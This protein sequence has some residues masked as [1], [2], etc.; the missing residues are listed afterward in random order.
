MQLVLVK[1]PTPPKVIIL[2]SW[3]YT[4]LCF[5]D[6][7]GDLPQ[8]SVLWS[9][10]MVALS[11]HDHDVSRAIELAGEI[12]LI[13]TSGPFELE[14]QRTMLWNLADKQ[15]EVCARQMRYY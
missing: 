11:Q 7:F 4:A 6:V 2:P 14:R 1:L 8:F 13:R 15:M 12:H 9:D 5:E 10:V 3:I